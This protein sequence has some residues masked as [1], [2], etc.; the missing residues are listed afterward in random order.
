MIDARPAFRLDDADMLH[1]DTLSPVAPLLQARL[2]ALPEPADAAA[3]ALRRSLLAWDGR[4]AA[5]SVAASQYNALRRA[6]TLILTRRS[7]LADVGRHPWGAVP[8][9]VSPVG[10]L[11]WALPTL[12]RDDDASMLGGWSWNDVVAAALAEV[13]SGPA[14][15]PWG[16]THQPRFTHPLS[17]SMPE[18]AAMLDPPS[19]PLGGD[20][21][22]VM[23][24]GQVP[25][26][27]PAGSYG[28]LCRYVFDVGDW[29]RSRWAV[30]HGASGHPGS[31]HYAD[32][33]AAWSACAMIPMRYGW[34]GIAAAATQTLHPAATRQ[35]T[36]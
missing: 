2:S 36:A 17:P 5:G 33:N 18:A 8:P 3:A 1:A 4:M 29:E 32:Q 26:A 22:T 6:M 14:P 30:F 10:Q 12:L 9:G 21:D 25:A 7:G 31:P 16:E 27:G 15:R 13:A 35:E 11:W 34:D 24:I 28:A 19:Q 23:A 20:G